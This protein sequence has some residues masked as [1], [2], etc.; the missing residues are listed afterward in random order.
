MTHITLATNNNKPIINKTIEFV[1][2]NV[3]YTPLNSLIDTS[4]KAS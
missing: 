1:K 2:Y 3:T 4:N